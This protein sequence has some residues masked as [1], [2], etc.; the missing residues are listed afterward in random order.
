[1]KDENSTDFSNN[2]EKPAPSLEPRQLSDYQKGY[3]FV[4]LVVVISI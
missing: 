3:L 1:M 4:T 2:K